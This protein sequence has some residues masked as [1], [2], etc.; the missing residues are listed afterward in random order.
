MRQ[1]TISGN[2][3]KEPVLN[4]TQN[5][6]QVANFSVAVRQDRPD[7]NG[8]YGTDWFRCSVWGKRAGTIAN[9]YHKGSRVTVTGSFELGDYNGNPQ[10]G[11]NVT[12]FDLPDKGNGQG[13]N[14]NQNNRQRQQNGYQGSN[15]SYPTNGDQIDIDDDQLP[16]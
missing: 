15:G 10:L 16:F 14:H 3:G 4:T 2:V 11:V 8:E 13:G 9:Y 6:M 12:D 5:G 7:G 1:I